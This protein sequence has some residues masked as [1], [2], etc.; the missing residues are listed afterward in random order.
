MK[1]LIGIV[2]IENDNL[3]RIGAANVLSATGKVKICGLS[4]SVSE[5]IKLVKEFQPSVVVLNIDLLSYDQIN[6]ISII[7]NF[8]STKIVIITNEKKRE[9]IRAAIKFGADCYYCKNSPGEQLAEKFIEAVFSAYNNELWIDPSI[10]QILIESFVSVSAEKTLGLASNQ[11]SPKELICLKLVATGMRSDSIA[12]RMHVAEGTIR[13]YL[14]SIFTKLNV[15]DKLNAIRKGI[16]IGIISYE[17]MEV[18][19]KMGE[20][21][22][23]KAVKVA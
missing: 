8:Q 18:G 11:L 21:Q 13:S 19:R 2:I 1:D 22:E 5:G 3:S 12:N 15:K 14:H 9:V 4:S 7:K 10:N 20:Y 17:D 6:T 16:Q 23:Q